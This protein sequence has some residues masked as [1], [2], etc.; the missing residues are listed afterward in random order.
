MA[1]AFPEQSALD[2]VLNELGEN[3][4]SC[5][6]CLE[7]FKKPKVLP[8]NHTFCEPCLTTLVKKT[9][10]LNCPSCA[11][12]CQLLHGGV[13]G[14]KD[15][16]FINSLVD[17][18]LKERPAD[19]GTE[20]PVCN[21]CDSKE[22]THWCIDCGVSLCTQCTK[23]HERFMKGH[24]VATEDEYT[25]TKSSRLVLQQMVF[26]SVHPT[27]EVKFYCQTCAVTVCT[28]CAIIKHRSAEH[29]HSELQEAADEYTKELRELVS[30]V[31]EKEK[32]AESCKED[33][34][35]FRE[36][37]VAKCK[38]EEEKVKKKT[39]EVIEKAQR[40]EKR[41]IEELKVEYGKKV[42]QG[43]V[44]IDEWEM[45]HGNMASQCG[46]VETLMHHGSPAQLMS[47]KQETLN[48]MNKLISMRIETSAETDMVEF[49]PAEKC[50]EE[51]ML[52]LLTLNKVK[53]HCQKKEEGKKGLVK[54]IGS[55]G[56]GPG[57]FSYPL[58]VRINRHRDLVIVD[59]GNNR[60]QIT[61]RDW[62]YKSS[63]TFSQFPKP[64]KPRDV[65]ISANDEYLMTD[66]H[67]KRIIVIDENGSLIKCFGEEVKN[68]WHI[69]TSPV[70]G[71][72]YVTDWDG[73][74]SENTDKKYHCIRKYSRDFQYVKSFG[75]YGTGQGQFKGPN[76]L[77]VGG[78]GVVFVSDMNNH[79]IQ[80]FD[81]DGEFLFKFGS[82]G[83]G[84]GHFS[85]PQGTA[86]DKK[87]NLYVSSRKNNLVQK[88]DNR[89][90]FISRIVSSNDWSDCRPTGLVV[91]EDMKVVVVD[92][93]DDCIRVF[94]Q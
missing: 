12:P 69:A 31:R 38:A 80:A 44:E 93:G 52:G 64:F 89:G 15:N 85:L 91:T 6:I 51:G 63:F 5:I 17:L 40:E 94:E 79:R 16:F 81:A 4:L 34:K 42:K 37:L 43:E 11:T 78:N 59:T 48:Q 55:K 87:G 2:K 8:C 23:P 45:K 20:K 33:A 92:Y 3:F 62:K 25:N 1:A 68:P 35:K 90:K 61:D 53:P 18:Y 47:T 73:K 21:G 75:I 76:Y 74:S 29:V 30:K 46:Y 7:L 71:S 77:H 32:A 54:I 84:Y 60:V 27:N 88:F 83:K 56:R 24:K 49:T 14:L 22:V 82:S 13:P 67:N 28:D 10:K 19:H 36:T 57:K 72:V 26:C 39:A 41:L 86:T 70:D 58:N 65:A 50:E 9:G 66:F